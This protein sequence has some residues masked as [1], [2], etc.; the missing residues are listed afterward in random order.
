MIVTV[1]VAAIVFVTKVGK[2][3]RILIAYQRTL[4][5]KLNVVV[6]IIVYGVNFT[7][8]T[9]ISC[10]SFPAW[11]SKQQYSLGIN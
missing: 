8:K 10:F 1:F 7:V 11:N 9:M 5:C 3:I 2:D 4:N 6:K